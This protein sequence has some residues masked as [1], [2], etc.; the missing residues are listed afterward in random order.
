[1]NLKHLT[2][3]TLLNDTKTLVLKEREMNTKV[4]HHLREIERRKLFSDLR[5]PS[6]FSYCVKELGYCES[7]AQRRIVASRMI[8]DIP[9][10]EEKIEEGVLS[11]T[12]LSLA[13]QYFKENSIKTPLEKIEV[14]TQIENKSKNECEKKLFEL[15]GKEIPAK[16][17]KKRLSSDKT[18]VSYILTEETLEAIESVKGLLHRPGTMDEVMGLMAKTTLG[19]LRK[20]KFKVTM[21]ADFFVKQ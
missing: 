19:F 12:N 2:D 13:N 14:L 7:S 20:K 9:E 8:E 1:M 6:L 5:Y 4:L 17:T 11:L 10:I 15:S 3:R 21:E 18:K 16:E